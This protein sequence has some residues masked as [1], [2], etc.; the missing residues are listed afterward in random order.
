MLLSD[1]QLSLQRVSADNDGYTPRFSAE[2]V[3]P[4]WH[5]PMVNDY[6][7]ND[8]IENCIR[9]LDLKGK[10][11]LEIGAGTG[12]VSMMFAKYGAQA[13]YACEVNAHMFEVATKII[14]DNGYSDRITLWNLSSRDLHAAMM[15][16]PPDIIFTETLDCGIV[17]EGFYDICVDV[18]RLS[19]DKT[20]VLPTR[21][22]QYA[23]I[24]SSETAWRLNHVDCACGLD[25][26]SLNDHRT[27]TYY[28][29]RVKSHA[30]DLL[31][32]RL[33]LAS[34]YYNGTGMTSCIKAFVQRA[35]P[36]HGILSWFEAELGDYRLTNDPSHSSHWH[37]AFHPFAQATQ[38]YA[39]TSVEV[40][41]R[42]D[43][44]CDVLEM[45][46]EN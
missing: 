7:R 18:K 32:S 17:N 5:F 28:P 27:R 30:I 20:L 14:R 45:C 8:A 2:K 37:Q 44:T 11:V 24:V 43:G 10:I 9:S 46:H 19:S 38:L 35:G 41:K 16:R 4:T 21:I 34:Y 36:A 40:R 26:T 33:E 22:K 13:V 6:T 23:H 29:I 15:P 42:E 3:F 1:L 39:G 12:L 31:T 25:V